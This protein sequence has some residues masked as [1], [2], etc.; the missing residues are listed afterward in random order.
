MGTKRTARDGRFQGVS[1]MDP[2]WTH[3]HV[4]A[5]GVNP[6]DSSY[7]AQGARAGIPEAAESTSLA[8]K[9]SGPQSP[10]GSLELLTNRAG[11]PIHDGGGFLVRDLA[12]GD[13]DDEYAGQDGYQVVTGWDGSLRMTL[14]GGAEEA[15]PVIRLLSGDLLLVEYN[16]TTSHLVWRMDANTFAWTNVHTMTLNPGTSNGHPDPALVQLPSG[17]VLYFYVDQLGVQV[18]ARFSDDDGTTWED[19]ATGVLT[20]TSAEPI[21]Q[22]AVAYTRGALV[23]FAVT[24]SGAPPGSAQ[25]WVSADLGCSFSRVGGDWATS[26]SPQEVPYHVSLVGLPSGAVAML[27]WHVGVGGPGTEVYSSRRID[28]TSPGY[29]TG[30]VDLFT[31]PDAPAFAES[32]C[33]LWSDEDGLLFGL[34]EIKTGTS[35][36][37]LLVRSKDGGASWVKQKGP[38]LGNRAAGTERLH[39]YRVASTGGRAAVVTRWASAGGTAGASLAVCYLGG[40]SWATVGS[41]DDDSQEFD[42]RSFI[43]WGQEPKAN[44]RFGGSYLPLASPLNMGWTAAGA[45]GETVTADNRWQIATVAA[46][47]SYT[48][49]DLASQPT[50]EAVHFGCSVRVVAGGSL[51][52]SAVAVQIRISDRD[53]ATPVAPTAINAME[54]RFTTTG[55]RMWDAVSGVQVGTDQAFDLQTEPGWF[56]VAMRRKAGG[57]GEAAVWYGREGGPL[58]R[59]A[60]KLRTATRADQA[61]ATPWLTSLVRWGHIAASTSTSEWGP[62]G[63]GF[64]AHA[65]QPKQASNFVSS[66]DNPTDLRA[67]DLPALPALLLDRVKIQAAD[68]PSRLDESWTIRTRYDY[69]VEN[70]DPRLSPSPGVPWRSKDDTAL[71]RIVWDLEGSLYSDAFLGNH[72]LLFLLLGCNF[73]TAHIKG[74]NVGGAA[75]DTLATLDAADGFSGLPWKRSGSTVQPDNGQVGAGERY[76]WR[77]QHAGDTFDLN[78]GETPLHRIQTHTEGA[79]R[80]DGTGVAKVKQPTLWL[81]RDNLAAGTSASGASGEVWCRDFGAVLREYAGTYQRFALEIPAQSTVEGYFRVGAFFPG[82]VLMF[83]QQYDLGMVWTREWNTDLTQRQ[84]GSRS[85]RVLGKRRRTVQIG[86]VETAVQAFQEQADDPNPDYL[87]SGLSSL[88]VASRG[89]VLRAMEGLLEQTDGP[90]EPIVYLARIPEQEAGGAP[91]L[92]TDRRRW[93]Y[94]RVQTDTKTEVL[95]ARTGEAVDEVER[96]NAITVEEEV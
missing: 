42:G 87:S 64:Y 53:D 6:E 67:R 12:F 39:D 84:D 36:Y 25:Q 58:R 50:I 4:R 80:V 78:A 55:F 10:D 66:W 83:G 32:S 89:D 27:Y 34:L 76:L 8:L 14:A 94:G 72:A 92:L 57:A 9:A 19:Y 28:P 13:A 73:K 49:T 85:A 40:H 41:V 56:K 31:S 93:L 24:S 2:R 69:G 20:V 65:F 11:H 52:S 44:G 30:R 3:S 63:F 96:L 46:L 37:T 90:S 70:L 21:Y 45:A 5:K 29:L 35:A 18:H 74:W 15:V 77:Q 43:G 47:R 38:T 33:A 48:V 68:G 79:W 75:W 17:R 95:A 51:T 59:L 91:L 61:P 16:A 1:R 22:L 82:D 7:T 71:E 23:L 62:L 86:W 54:L 60:V 26:T 88:A 81:E